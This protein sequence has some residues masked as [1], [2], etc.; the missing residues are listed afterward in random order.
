MNLC[1]ITS[2]HKGSLEQLRGY[3]LRLSRYLMQ[4]TARPAFWSLEKSIKKVTKPTK[5]VDYFMYNY[6]PGLHLMINAKPGSI[7]YKHILSSIQA[8]AQTVAE[9]FARDSAYQ[10]HASGIPHSTFHM[11]SSSSTTT[12][13]TTNRHGSLRP[14]RTRLPLRDPHA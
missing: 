12:T 6:S 5:L 7:Y 9:A 8:K 4:T 2:C 14:P 3:W 1:W 10:A 13:T 11:T